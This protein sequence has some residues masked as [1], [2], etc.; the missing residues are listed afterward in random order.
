MSPPELSGWLAQPR[1]TGSITAIAQR[2]TSIVSRLA[3]GR[4]GL[5]APYLR[6]DTPPLGRPRGAS[7]PPR[8]H[9]RGRFADDL[10]EPSHR[11]LA[12]PLL[13]SVTLG[14]DDDDAVGGD[15]LVAPLQQPLLDVLRQR[16]RPHVEAQVHGT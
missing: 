6:I 2:S 11:V 4:L 9:H 7:R 3:T 16:R 10:M 5:S 13:A 1:Q 12:V 14:L 15:A 8:G